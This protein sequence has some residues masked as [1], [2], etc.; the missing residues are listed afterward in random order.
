MF[1]EMIFMGQVSSSLCILWIFIPAEL[2]AQFY[3]YV[4][5]ALY[6]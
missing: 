5:T 3:T 4:P 6:W 2:G 1:M